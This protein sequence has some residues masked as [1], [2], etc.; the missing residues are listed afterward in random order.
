M[1]LY[2]RNLQFTLQFITHFNFIL[3]C[4]V[5]PSGSSTAESSMLD[6]AGGKNLDISNSWAAEL[7][8]HPEDSD[9]R[10]LN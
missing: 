8:L 4:A 5:F 3:N 6:D 10:F 1:I 2:K 7:N 9:A